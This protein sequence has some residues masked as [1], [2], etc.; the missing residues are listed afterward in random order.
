MNDKFKLKENKDIDKKELTDIKNDSFLIEDDIDQI[1]E[2][3]VIEDENYIKKENRKRIIKF[4]LIVFID[5]LTSGLLVGFG[6]LWQNKT[7]LLAICNAF[8]LAFAVKFTFAWV[9]L[10]YNMTI[11][12]PIIHGTKTFFLLFVGKKPKKDYYSYIQDIKEKPIPKSIYIYTFISAL[13]LLIPA[14]VTTVIVS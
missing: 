7:N 9:I 5:L 11:L 13:I 4:S 1:E 10:M 3:L 2:E 6:L 12:S 8:W 14:I